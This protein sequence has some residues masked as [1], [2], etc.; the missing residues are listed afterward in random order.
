[1]IESFPLSLAYYFLGGVIVNP[2]FVF[3]FLEVV[4]SWSKSNT[5][6]VKTL[7]NSVLLPWFGFIDR[8]QV[9][10]HNF[11]ATSFDQSV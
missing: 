5:E 9:R 3:F 7:R 6:H 8:M 4:M 10:I 11:V 1:M 2:A